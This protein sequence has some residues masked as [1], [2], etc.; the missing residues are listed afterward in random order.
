MNQVRGYYLITRF[1]RTDVVAL[2][3]QKA[4]LPQ[5]IWFLLEAVWIM[6]SHQ[7]EGNTIGLDC[8]CFCG[9][10]NIREVIAFK[11]NKATDP[12]TQASLSFLKS[13]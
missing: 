2:I 7:H 3:S 13:N 12:M 1:T 8:R 9:E 4:K 11:N 5:T 6:V 10:D